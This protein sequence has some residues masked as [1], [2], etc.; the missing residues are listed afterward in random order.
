MGLDP[1]VHVSSYTALLP[2]QPP[3]AVLTPDS[4]VTRPAGAYSRSKAESD[5]VARRYR[6]QGAPG[7]RLPREG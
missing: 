6:E 1:V 5:Q 7:D 2:P 4:P 3:D